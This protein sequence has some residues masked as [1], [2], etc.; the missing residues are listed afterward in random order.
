MSLLTLKTINAEPAH[1]FQN[2]FREEITLTPNSRVQVVNMLINKD[3]E[4]IFTAD[5]NK[6]QFR[7]GGPTLFTTKTITF[8]VGTYSAGGLAKIIKDELNRNNLMKNY[9]F[10]CDFG[11]TSEDKFTITWGQVDAPA[12]NG[13]VWSQPAYAV[14]P[15]NTNIAHRHTHNVLQVQPDDPAGANSLQ[16]ASTCVGERGIF[17][18]GGKVN[19]II[20]PLTGG[21]Y[22]RNAI[23]FSRGYMVAPGMIG[24]DITDPNTRIQERTDN[25]VCD[26]YVVFQDDQVAGTPPTQTTLLLKQLN[27]VAGTNYPN[28]GWFA[29]LTKYQRRLDQLFSGTAFNYGVDHLQLTMT[30]SGI[31]NVKFEISHDTA[32]DGT[33]I[34]NVVFAQTGSTA[35]FNSTI[36]ESFY[37]LIPVAFLAGGTAANPPQAITLSGVYDTDDSVNKLADVQQV[38]SL[39]ASISADKNV[40]DATTQG[41]NVDEEHTA[42]YEDRHLIDRPD[43]LKTGTAAPEVLRVGTMK[44]LSYFQFGPVS[45]ADFVVG[46][47]TIPDNQRPAQNVASCADILGMDNVFYEGQNI[48]TTKSYTSSREPDENIRAPGLLVELPDFNIKSY[49]GET[50]DVMKTISVVPKEDPDAGETQGT[51][52]YS[53]RYPIPIHLNMPTTQNINVIRCRIRNEDGTFAQFLQSPTQITLLLDEEPNNMKQEIVDAFERIASREANRQ[54]QLIS[55]IN[56]DTAL[57]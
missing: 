26:C 54:N 51:I 11:T 4:F 22:G 3:K 23:G 46:G 28:P 48:S 33:F 10:D 35:S 27:Q 38:P 7:L 24:E 40:N 56:A 17:P 8:P 50:G 41:T 1:N 21:G 43:G 19:A 45:D 34:D 49:N 29:M 31:R 42:G 55:T 32:G 20:P 14:N 53:M 37:P 6:L 25:P 47:G 9:T 13:N 44:P 5:N 52:T 15:G 30:I 16:I 39:V 12:M 57:I 36:K 2:N 18:D